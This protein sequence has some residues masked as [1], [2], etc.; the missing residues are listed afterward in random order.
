MQLCTVCG[1]LLIGGFSFTNI[2]KDLRSTQK[3]S[4]KL[5]CVESFIYKT[6]TMTYDN[7]II[8]LRITF[9]IMTWTWHHCSIGI[10]HITTSYETGV[11]GNPCT[12]QTKDWARETRD[13]LKACDGSMVKLKLI[14]LL[15]GFL[16]MMINWKLGVDLSSVKVELALL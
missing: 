4:K 12:T 3:K 13:H 1:L 14:G 16:V 6:L 8:R 2:K 9:D 7:D 11:K 5:G 15:V 10:Q